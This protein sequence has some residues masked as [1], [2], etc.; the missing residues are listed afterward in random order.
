MNALPGLRL[1]MEKLLSGK[2]E[3]GEAAD[4]DYSPANLGRQI[5]RIQV[6]PASARC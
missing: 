2:G 1:Q 5:A 6:G 4:G 3:A